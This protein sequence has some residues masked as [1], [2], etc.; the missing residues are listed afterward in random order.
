MDEHGVEQE[1]AHHRR[2]D[3][4]YLCKPVYMKLLITVFK[5][6]TIG[7]LLSKEDKHVYTRIISMAIFKRI[8]LLKIT[9]NGTDSLLHVESI[10]NITAVRGNLETVKVLT[11]MGALCLTK[12]MDGAALNGKLEIVKWL[13][14]NRFEGCTT[15]AMDRAAGNGYIEVVKWLHENR[16]ETF[17][18]AIDSAAECG[19]LDVVQF[20]HLNRTEGCDFALVL[21]TANCH[22]EVVKYLVENR[23]S[24]DRLPDALSAN[25]SKKMMRYFLKSSVIFKD[26]YAMIL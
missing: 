5:S 24:L 4:W 18:E 19:Y 15:K 12:A 8:D 6:E 22:F 7:F 2:K 10:L 25:M 3:Y 16:F 17:A 9:Y 14:E 13:H 11:E 20:L 1:F 26:L 21:A 23:L